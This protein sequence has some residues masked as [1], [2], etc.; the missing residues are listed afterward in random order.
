MI[1]SFMV[2]QRSYNYMTEN[3]QQCNGAEFTAL[4]DIYVDIDVREDRR[5]P[6]L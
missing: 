4:R 2:E 3:F 6:S 5:E 1:K